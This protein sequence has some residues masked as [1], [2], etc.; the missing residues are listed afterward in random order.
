ML[1]PFVGDDCS[2]L[3]ASIPLSQNFGMRYPPYAARKRGSALD[4]SSDHL[5]H[6]AHRVNRE[7]C[8]TEPAPRRRTRRLGFFG[9]A[10]ASPRAIVAASVIAHSTFMVR[11]LAGVARWAYSTVGAFGDGIKNLSSASRHTS[12]NSYP[13]LELL[14]PFSGTFNRIHLSGNLSVTIYLSQRSHLTYRAILLP[15]PRLGRN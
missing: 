14:V 9:P 10:A 7:W 4:R 11:L 6:A 13:L 1:Q 8:R 15:L 3:Q 5:P 2:I 12:H